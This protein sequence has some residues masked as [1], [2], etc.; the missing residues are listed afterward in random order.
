MLDPKYLR[1]DL[2]EAAAR[3]ATRNYTLDVETL[4]KYTK[5]KEDTMEN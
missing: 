5:K 4:C 3:L 1:T 2:E